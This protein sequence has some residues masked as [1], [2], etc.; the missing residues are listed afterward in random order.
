MPRVAKGLFEKR[1]EEKKIFDNVKG[2]LKDMK[3]DMLKRV[4]S[5]GKNYIVIIMIP[6]VQL[7]KEGNVDVTARNSSSSYRGR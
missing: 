3:K 7:F 1:R 2:K 5:T 4:N 6:F